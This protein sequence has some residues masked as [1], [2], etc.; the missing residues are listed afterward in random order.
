MAKKSV[1]D[2]FAEVQILTEKLISFESA[3]AQKIENLEKETEDKI[4]KLENRI[5]YLE[6]KRSISCERESDYPYFQCKECTE[7]FNK[8]DNLK[9]HIPNSIP[10]R[11]VNNVLRQAS[12][13]KY[14]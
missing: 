1:N 2:L 13:W 8:K 12:V 14:I 10:A 11:F 9:K 3:Q 6:Q 7:T 5:R 4:I